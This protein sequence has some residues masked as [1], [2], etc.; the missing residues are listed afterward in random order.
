[1]DPEMIDAVT[2]VV[3]K[4]TDN[5]EMFT[6]FDVTHVVR[7]TVDDGALHYQIKQLVHDLH[8]NGKLPSDYVRDDVDI[9]VDKKQVNAFVYHPKWKD[10]K[11]YDPKRFQ[12]TTSSPFDASG[13]SILPP[14]VALI[15]AANSANFTLT[16][17]KP[18]LQNGRDKRGRICVP[19]GLI[20]KIKR[21]P[22]Q[23]V[24]VSPRISGM[25]VYANKPNGSKV[26]DVVTYTVDRS[27]NIRISQ[28]TIRK[29]G[30]W[31]NLQVSFFVAT[32][33]DGEKVVDIY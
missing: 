29:T 25:S 8:S 19:A 18:K 13:K 9:D 3:S 28:Q 16:A 6:A 20:R 27:G 23:T 17:P 31:P 26:H 14:A 11:S 24:Y 30:M 4:M 7:N 21:Y 2:D 15:P 10:A 5:D 22:G 33:K 12:D 1:M 32:T